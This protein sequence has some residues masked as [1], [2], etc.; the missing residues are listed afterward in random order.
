MSAHQ[1]IL[2][3]RAVELVES[4]NLETAQTLLADFAAA[5]LI[6]TYALM[7]EIRPEGKPSIA[8]RDSQVPAEEWERI[9]ASGNIE[10]AL[11]G[12][13]VRLEGTPYKG[14]KPTVQITGIS[15]SET[16]LVKVL[17]R[18][19]AGSDVARNTLGSGENTN[20][21]A[22][23]LV[24]PSKK[25][26]APVPKAVPPIKPGDLFASVA[27]AVQATRLGRTKIDELMRK[28]ILER[29]KVGTRALITVKSL[30]ALVGSK[31]SD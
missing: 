14:G 22:T 10:V 20:I 17:D 11:N 18:Y 6:K 8:Y 28:G 30:E 24:S 4:R 25:R 26:S 5:G 21:E 3:A 31:V 7:R 9:V 2:P 27:Q 1:P 13:T 15:F 19:C 16:S 12:G 23:E 29:Q